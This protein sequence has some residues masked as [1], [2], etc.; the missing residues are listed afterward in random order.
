MQRGEEL[1]KEAITKLNCPNA[2]HRLA[3]LRRD[4]Q[5]P[6]EAAQLLQRAG[7]EH[8]YAPSLLVLGGMLYSGDE[9]PQDIDRAF[10]LFLRAADLGSSAAMFRLG[11][12]FSRG[13]GG[14]PPDLQAAEFWWRAAA[15]LGSPAA[16]LALARKLMPLPH[17]R[18]EGCFW[19]GKAVRH[20]FDAASEFRAALVP[21]SNDANVLF[22]LGEALQQSLRQYQWSPPL[23]AREQCN[24]TMAQ[25]V[26]LTCCDRARNAVMCFAGLCKF[27][28][29]LHRDLAKPICEMVWASRSSVSVWMSAQEVHA[30]NP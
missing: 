18:S 24:A 27:R 1:L 21:A 16:M 7:S 5:L 10:E 2:I 8:G 19:L 20:R 6:E 28:S 29:I 14:K 15:T 11:V 13:G 9:L 26:F 25:T 12:C 30:Q 4:Q 23:N 17:M 22:R 3:L